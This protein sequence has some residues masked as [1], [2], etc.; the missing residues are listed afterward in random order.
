MLIDK[1]GN[2]YCSAHCEANSNIVCPVCGKGHIV[3]RVAK[4]G[5]TAGNVF[6]ACDQF[7]RCKALFVDMPTSEHCEIC[8]SVMLKNKDGQLY[9]SNSECPNNKQR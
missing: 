8:N 9:C 7:P 2:K 5:K 6:Y 1:E 4:R 3:K